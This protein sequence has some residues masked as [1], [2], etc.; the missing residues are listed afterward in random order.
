MVMDTYQAGNPAYGVLLQRLTNIVGAGTDAQAVKDLIQKAVTP[1]TGK[2]GGW[3]AAMLSGLGEG[4]KRKRIDFFTLGNEQKKL[5]DATF[6]NHSKDVRKSALELLK[7]IGVADSVQLRAGLDRAVTLAKNR[8]LSDE[9]RAEAINFLSLGNPAP[10]VKLLEGFIVPQEQPIVQL[11]ALKVLSQVPDLTVCHYVLKR[12]DALTPETRD[13][14]LNT[15]MTS[16]ARMTLLLSAIETKKVKPE[17]V[18]WPRTVQLMSHG[19]IKIRE[20]ARSLLA[21]GA[22][23]VI[24]DDYKKSLEMEGDV[25][26]G[27]LVYMQHCALCHQVRG[28]IGVAY[29]PD[30]G[31][32]HN[33]LSK[34]LLANI[35]DASL[36]IAPGYDLWEVELKDGDLIQGMIM[37]ETSAAIK[38]RTAPGV[39]KTI[40][41]QDIKGLKGL[42]MS[43]MPAFA[44]QLD[45]QKMADLI[46]FLKNSRTE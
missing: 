41:R 37:S 43:V 16:P 45:P 19:D 42:S 25:S 27:K 24:S 44:S 3:Q 7:R 36:S 13:A 23:E 46:A 1:T 9:K 6:Q 28:Q 33:W 4:L 11:A 31:T 8:K 34:D 2:S 30:L 5:I 26:R 35:L 14:A 22:G 18:G 12:W 32:V 20:Q 39:D 40:S 21:R 17:S 29:G 15:F 10:Y 38:L